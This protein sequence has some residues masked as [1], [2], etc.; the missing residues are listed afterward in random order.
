MIDDSPTKYEYDHVIETACIQT[1]TIST[2]RNRLSILKEIMKQEQK[3]HS[4]ASTTT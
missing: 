2:T 3:K 4:K 1:I